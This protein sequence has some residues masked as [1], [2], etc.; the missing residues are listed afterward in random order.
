M[1]NLL[2]KGFGVSSLVTAWEL[3]KY[4]HK[5]TISSPICSP[6]GSASW[7]AG[8][9]LAPFCEREAA[10]I[11]VQ[12]KGIDAIKWW[13]ENFPSFVKTKGTIVIATERDNPELHRFANVT[14]HYSWLKKSE[15]AELEPHIADRFDTA[16][17]YK[18]E[19]HLDPR[20]VLN[21][22][23]TELNNKG[24]TYVT[25]ANPKDFDYI[26]DCTGKHRIGIDKDLRPI[27]GEM[28]IIKSDEIKINRSIRFLHP[29]IPIYLVPRDQNQFMIGA[30]M[31]ESGSNEPI[32]SRSMMEFL[33]SAYSIH[34]A[35]A[36]A[37]IIE[38]SVGIRPAYPNNLP[39]IVQC[40]KTIFINGLYRHGYLLTP[41]LAQEITSLIK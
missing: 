17:F 8:G 21:F 12:Q 26:I 23:K 35:F 27:R 16:L 7:Y 6:I 34:P 32:S 41:Y 31:I 37:H 20:K 3:H 15:I 24:V 22:I 2:I 10:D 29:R 19:A 38:A 28:L 11:F 9:M 40:G 18:E 14:E 13:K 30:T 36:A 25:S 1:L 39:K 4:G 33:N 5:I